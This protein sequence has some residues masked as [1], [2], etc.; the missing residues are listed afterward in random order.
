MGEARF[1]CGA[2]AHLAAAGGR[3]SATT[4]PALRFA[5]AQDGRPRNAWVV[6]D[7]RAIALDRAV[8]VLGRAPGCD[9]VIHDDL[10]SRRT[11]S[12]SFDGDG[13]CIV[14]D[15]DSVCGVVVNGRKLARVGLHAGDRVYVGSTVFVVESR[16]GLEGR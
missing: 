14:T 13:H 2:C 3:E 8:T 1:C 7:G 9:I 11:R 10:L 15:L 12:I 6:F 5:L 4:G 16:D